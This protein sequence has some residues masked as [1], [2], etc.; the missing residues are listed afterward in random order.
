MKN[1]IEKITFSISE[2]FDY[3]KENLKKILQESDIFLKE[4]ILSFVFSNAKFL[5]P[6][7]IFLFSDLLEIK[8]R[9]ILNIALAV[10][11]LHNA[12]L[13]HDDIIDD[14]K[15]RRNKLT[16]HS[17]FNTKIAI[18]MG[19]LLLSYALEI[20]SETP[21]TIIKIF[22]NKIIKTIKGEIKQNKNCNKKMSYEMYFEKTYDKT[23]NLFFAGL[24]SLF[25]L[26][27]IDDF[28]KTNLREYLTNFCMAFQIQNDIKDI[29]SDY[30]NGNYTLP[31]IYYFEEN[32]A[33]DK[34]KM[35]KYVN[36]VKDVADEYKTKA[37][38]AISL[39]KINKIK[40]LI[41]LLEII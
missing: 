31:L 16:M 23:A 17:K 14:S 30:Q 18:L 9:N 40:P 29:D 36:R 24:E 26:K 4:D 21:Q 8:D 10:E 38:S 27:N 7:L 28:I 5:R 13:I 34:N 41:E 32:K 20:L 6:R 3:F 1:K 22:S 12:S 19:D 35:E 25:V 15:M 33:Y 2:E 11:L 37:K 39:I